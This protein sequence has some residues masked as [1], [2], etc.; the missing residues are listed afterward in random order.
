[1]FIRLLGPLVFVVIYL[2]VAVPSYYYQKSK[3]EYSDEIG[4]S[5][6]L[7]K[8]NQVDSFE[9]AE[10]AWTFIPEVTK[11][12][13]GVKVK[14]YC[15]S[16]SLVELLYESSYQEFGQAF[17]GMYNTD[18]YIVRVD[19]GNGMP[20]NF[21]VRLHDEEGPDLAVDCSKPFDAI[22]PTFVGVSYQNAPQDEQ[23]A[24]QVSQAYSFYDQYLPKDH[25]NYVRV[26]GCLQG[27]GKRQTDPCVDEEKAK[28]KKY[29]YNRIQIRDTR[30]KT[31]V[32]EYDFSQEDGI[33]EV[34]P[35]E[36]IVVHNRYLLLPVCRLTP[37]HVQ[38]SRSRSSFKG[39]LNVDFP[40]RCSSQFDPYF[41]RTVDLTTG[42]F[43][44][45]FSTGKG[46]HSM[47]VHDGGL[48]LVFSDAQMVRIFH[49]LLDG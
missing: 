21:Q 36:A 19:L 26:V 2:V 18:R 24:Y 6:K 25:D 1:M 16:Q 8:N 44:D 41:L 10:V 34:M 40:T 35:R 14:E 15:V 22:T 39:D 3:G 4:V 28:T 30:T 38:D 29:D 33:I 31:T 17:S 27:P 11:R 48:F 47:F 45:E 32:W 43:V 9:D 23:T 37:A 20:S 7:I 13:D 42:E 49:P 12:A 5:E 46:I